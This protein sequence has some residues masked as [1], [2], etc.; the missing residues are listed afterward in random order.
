LNLSYN[1]IKQGG[2]ICGHDYTKV[3]FEG[4]VRAV[5]EFCI[6]KNLEIKYIT[7]DGCPSFCIIKK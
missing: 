1:K 4:V 7:K 3:M 5:D 2:F 6:E